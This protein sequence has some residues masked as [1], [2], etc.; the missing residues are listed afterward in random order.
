M[1]EGKINVNVFTAMKVDIAL[2][3]THNHTMT[4]NVCRFWCLQ[5]AEHVLARSN[6]DA[7]VNTV[8]VWTLHGEQRS[9]DT[10]VA[11]DTE[12]PQLWQVAPL[13][14]DEERLDEDVEEKPTLPAALRDW[15]AARAYDK[16]VSTFPN[17]IL[18]AFGTDSF[19]HSLKNDIKKSE[20]PRPDRA[21]K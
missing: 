20:V 7:Y 1:A 14:A 15:E 5:W 3:M 21:A 19:Y 13:V 2:L 11:F 9:D 16:S 17:L 10:E 6:Y 12:C 8:R 18:N 4:E